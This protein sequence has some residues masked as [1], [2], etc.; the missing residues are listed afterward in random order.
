MP[1]LLGSPQFA[2]IMLGVTKIAEGQCLSWAVAEFPGEAKC[3]LVARGG[4]GKVA[5]GD[6]NQVTGA[7]WQQR[8]DLLLV[9]SGG[10]VTSSNGQVKMCSYSRG[11]G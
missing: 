2:G 6:Y 9:A 8:A 1:R 4:L 10:T 5:Y 3:A 11:A 7:C